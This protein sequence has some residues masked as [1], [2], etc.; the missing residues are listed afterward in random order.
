MLMKL[1]PSMYRQIFSGPTDESIGKF[2]KL[3]DE[4]PEE[5]CESGSY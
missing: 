5:D 4:I 2:G 3:I 1:N